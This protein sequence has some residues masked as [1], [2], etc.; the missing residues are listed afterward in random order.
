MAPMTLKP[1]ILTAIFGL[2][3]DVLAEITKIP[4]A[5][6]EYSSIGNTNG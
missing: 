6:A 2:A 5:T 1:N 4:P 3:T